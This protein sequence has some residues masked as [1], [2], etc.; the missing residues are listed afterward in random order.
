[1]TFAEQ[2]D[3]EAGLQV[4]IPFAF[5]TRAVGFFMGIGFDAHPGC[6]GLR[7]DIHRRPLAQIAQFPG[8]A[9]FYRTGKTFGFVF[10][11]GNV[12]T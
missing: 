3:A 1:M 7:L 5:D 10:L 12:F 6:L 11:R 2:T 8:I 4:A 9:R